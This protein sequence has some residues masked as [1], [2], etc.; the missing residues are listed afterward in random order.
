MLDG[1]RKIWLA[2][3]IVDF[4]CSHDGLLA[5][6]NKV[7]IEIFSGHGILFIGRDKKKLKLL[8]ADENGLWVAYKKFHRQGLKIRLEFL[9]QPSKSKISKSELK[10]LLSG[11]S[12][13]A[14]GK[15]A[16]WP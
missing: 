9:G 12:Y 16:P 11:A 13:T 5:Q 6:A 1:I 2:R 8:F 10:M 15:P 3:H 4:R 7:G 14:G